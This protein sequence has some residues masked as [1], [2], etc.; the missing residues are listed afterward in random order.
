MDEMRK[1][2]SLISRILRAFGVSV[3]ASFLSGFAGFLAFWV[4]ALSL[5]K[6]L[7]AEELPFDGPDFSLVSF[8]LL[9][10]TLI[11][12]LVSFGAQMRTAPVAALRQGM[13]LSLVLLLAVST[14]GVVAAI[15]LND[16]IDRGLTDLLYLIGAVTPCAF[17]VVVHWALVRAR[18]SSP[19]Q[20]E[21]K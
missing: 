12:G 2:A 19:V 4:F 15:Y 9:P 10:V 6:I 3:G 8:N 21:S 13:L 20:E 1:P 5:V 14:G 11:V 17:A 7:G 16:G 18:I